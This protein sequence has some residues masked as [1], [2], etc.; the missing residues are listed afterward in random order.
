[1]IGTREDGTRDLPIALAGQVYVR[2]TVENG[3][4]VAGDLLVSS[5]TPGTAMRAR[6]MQLAFGAVVGKALQ[7]YD[8]IGG[9]EGLIRM[10]V[11]VR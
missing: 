10:L 3:P 4:I 1:M 2:V 5:T 6:D 9:A 11:M 8:G 7:P